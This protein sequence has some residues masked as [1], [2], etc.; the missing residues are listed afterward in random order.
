MK[1]YM[2]INEV[3]RHEYRVKELRIVLLG[4]GK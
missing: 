4:H 2:D 1:E 3:S